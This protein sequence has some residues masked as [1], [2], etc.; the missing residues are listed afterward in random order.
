MRKLLMVIWAALTALTTPAWAQE[1]QPLHTRHYEFRVPFQVEPPQ[2]SGI[3]AREVQL[4]VSDNQRDWQLFG[5]VEPTAGGFAFRAPR[6]GEYWFVIRTIDQAGRMLP[7]PNGPTIPEM[8]VVVD[9]VP[10]VLELQAGLGPSGEIVIQWYAQ[11]PHAAADRPTIE[12]R[13]ANDVAAPWQ[14]VAVGAGLEGSATL[15]GMQGAV[16]VRAR[17]LDLAGNEA[18]KEVRV[19][20]GPATAAPVSN[21]PPMAEP[22]QT[23]AYPPVE[24]QPPMG[25]APTTEPAAPANNAGVGDLFEHTSRLQKDPPVTPAAPVIPA[26]P[27]VQLPPGVTPLVVNAMRFTLEYDVQTIGP[28]GLGKVELWGTPDAGQT[29]RR[30]GTDP[31]RR[32]PIAVSVPAEG[33]YGFRMVVENNTGIG[34]KPPVAGDLPDVWVTVDTTKP[35][36][37]LVAIEE[38]LRGADTEMIIRWEASDRQLGDRPVSLFF[39]TSPNGK[40]LP[41]AAGLPNTGNYVWKLGDRA[42]REI[43]IRLKVQDQAGNDTLI[44]SSS[45]AVA[46]YLKPRGRIGGANPMTGRQVAPLTR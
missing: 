29:W 37:K 35:A 42:P 3:Q 2:N 24:V 10:P 21:Y 46:D 13:P 34:D 1:A 12:Y 4:H 45:A 27:P 9:T 30:F 6:D 5:T 33:T 18:R 32:S 14:A 25:A 39:A 22:S 20:A 44:D 43:H 19:S 31:D 8:K 26:L 41:I 11:D 40:W 38:T 15:P 16:A 28:S 36:A 17:F 7:E 23:A